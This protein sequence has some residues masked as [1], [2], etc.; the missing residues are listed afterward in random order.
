MSRVPELRVTWEQGVRLV[1][2]GGY[3]F[4]MACVACVVT[5]VFRDVR[6]ASR[7]NIEGLFCDD[8]RLDVDLAPQHTQ[9]ALSKCHEGNTHIHD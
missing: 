8:R 6:G 7:I 9:W 2:Q 1:V 4:K 5:C 3:L